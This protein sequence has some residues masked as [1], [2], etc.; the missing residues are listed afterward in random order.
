MSA[1]L[2]LIALI[3]NMSRTIKSDVGP[4]LQISRA[5]YVEKHGVLSLLAYLSRIY[6]RV[7]IMTPCCVS[8]F[9]SVTRKIAGSITPLS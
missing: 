4:I 9:V 5:Q 8:H 2:K 6:P 3:S 7:E 1:F